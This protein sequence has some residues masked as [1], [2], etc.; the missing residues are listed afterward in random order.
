[1][2]TV[3]GTRVIRSDGKDKVTGDGRYA[4]DLTLTG[5]AHAK[6]RY[7]DH[8]HA[9]ILSIDTSKARALDGVFAVITQDDVPDVRHGAFIQDRTLFARDV[10]RYEGDVIA[11]VAALTPE[12]AERAAA[13]IDIEYEVLPAVGH[14]DAAL[15]P[16]APQIHPDWESYEGSEDVVREGNICSRSTIVKGDADAAMEKADIVVSERYEADMSHA[17]PIEP[18]AVVAQWQGDKVTI[19]SSTQVPFIARSGVATTLEMP[20][21]HVRVIVPY[22]GG[23]FGGKCE[24]H[25]EAHIAALS[26]AARRPVRLVFS[27]EEEFLAPDHRR[28]GQSIDL[29]TGVM[30]D[31]TIVARRG[32]A[33]AGQRRLHDRQPVLPAAGRD[34][35]RRSVQGRE[36]VRRLDPGLLEHDAVRLGARPH[37]AAGLLGGGAAHGLRGRQAGD[38]SRRVPAQDDRPH[39]RRGPHPPG[40]RSDRRRRDAGPGGRDDRLRPGPARGR[41][42]RRRLRLVA[43]VR[44]RLRRV[45]EAERR[46]LRAR[47]SPAPRSAAPAP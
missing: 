8:P 11:A 6:F 23:G 9:R 28:E 18:H 43:V 37:G 47:S 30:Q 14:Q 2:A 41:G 3:V 20:E 36:R 33:G 38:G 24:F 40:V 1:M 16:G 21:S 19:W 45:S 4:A 27:R 5:M 34:D 42:D 44:H 31:G 12:I 46:R 35:G 10:V 29:E 39:R 26:R 7:A 15:E 17:V 22:L 32:A 25:F 13:L